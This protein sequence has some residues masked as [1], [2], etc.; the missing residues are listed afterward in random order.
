[1][2]SSSLKEKGFVEWFPLKTVSISNLP[3]SKANVFV[4]IDTTVSG[5]PLSDILYIGRSKKPSKRLLG[6]YLAGYGG[7]N[8]QKIN[9]KL[10]EEGYIEKT[11]ISFVPTEKPRMMQ[12]ELLLQFAQEHGGFPNWNPKKKMPKSIKTKTE[13][14]PKAARKTRTPRKAKA[15]VRSRASTI[16]KTPEKTKP[17]EKA[18]VEQAA[19]EKSKSKNDTGT[20]LGSDTTPPP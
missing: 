1:M 14:K 17:P 3:L 6:G 11:A 15:S 13:P 20:A 9:Q 10:L 2:N 18:K 19:Q 4:I 8:T 12:N 7:K 16:S 5:T